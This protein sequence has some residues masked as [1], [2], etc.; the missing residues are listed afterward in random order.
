MNFLLDANV[1][2]DKALV[3]ARHVDVDELFALLTGNQICISR[4]SL[5]A[6]AWYIT[7]RSPDVFRRL[8]MD[9]SFAGVQVLD[10][11]LEELPRALDAMANYRLDF[12]D[13]FNLAVSE[14]YDVAIVS[15]DADFDRTPRGRQTPSQVVA[16]IRSTNP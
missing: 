12:D 14:K 3:R 16:Q 11:A 10:L 7:P 9:L 1:I 5:H 4:F 2:I 15:F 13:A 8:C 6:V